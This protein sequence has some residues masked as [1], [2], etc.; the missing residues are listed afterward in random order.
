MNHDMDSLRSR[1]QQATRASII[2][3]FLALSHDEN[4]ISI[5]MPM[6]ADRAGLSVRTVYRYFPTKDDLQTAGANFFNDRVTDR[7]QSQVDATNF[8]T[9]L[10]SLWLDFADEM[11]AVM[12]E[13]STAAGR[14]LRATRLAE[15]RA[16]V[17]AAAGPSM[18][19][20]TID[21]IVAVASSSM[22]LELVDRMG[23]SPEAAAAMAARMVRLILA[24]ETPHPTQ[25][26]ET[27]ETGEHDRE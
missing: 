14:A 27:P 7:L 25:D 11:P 16:A 2:D 19:A 15:S 18:D 23:H 21:L 20:E 22:F 17:Q 26:P 9:Y 6:V 12:A 3:A 24:A 8:D 5:S 1:Q 13:H 4:T 10:K